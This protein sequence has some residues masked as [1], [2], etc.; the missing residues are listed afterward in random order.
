L[1]WRKWEAKSLRAVWHPTVLFREQEPDAHDVKITNEELEN[2]HYGQDQKRKEK[3]K[4]REEINSCRRHG[5]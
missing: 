1:G 2:G 5:F 3:R 4:R